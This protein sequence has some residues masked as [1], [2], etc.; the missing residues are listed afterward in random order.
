MDIFYVDLGRTGTGHTG[1]VADPYAWSDV[2]ASLSAIE[3]APLDSGHTFDVG[4]HFDSAQV[5]VVY[6]CRGAGDVLN[7][8]GSIDLTGLRFSP[9]SGIEITSWDPW[10]HGLPVFRTPTLSDLDAAHAWFK[11]TASTQVKLKIHGVVFGISLPN[12]G[13]DAKIISV[14]SPVLGSVQFYNN[15]VVD[16][17]AGNQ[18]VTVRGATPDFKTICTGN[19]IVY[20]SA[21]TGASSAF[22][23]ENG[24]LYTGLNFAVQASSASNTVIFGTSTTVAYSNGNA[25]GLKPSAIT[26]T[27]VSPTSFSPDYLGLTPAQGIWG[28]SQVTPANEDPVWSATAGIPVVKTSVF[29]PVHQGKLLG[30]GTTSVPA[31]IDVGTLSTD[32]LGLDRAPG[33]GDA[34]AFQKTGVTYSQTVHVDLAA[35]VS[36][37]GSETSP[38]TLADFVKDFGRRAPIDYSLSYVLRN[39][40]AAAL[41]G[42]DLGPLAP[43]TTASNRRFNG[44]GQVSITGYKTYAKTLP[45]LK[46]AAITP[47]SG[48][49]TTMSAMKLEFSGSDFIVP[50]APGS[51]P[52]RLVNSVVRS[53]PTA[54]GVI[55]RSSTGAGE[56]SLFG[57]SV[58][59]RHSV[60]TTTGVFLYPAGSTNSEISLCAV[61]LNNQNAVSV[62]NVK[63]RGCYVSTGT[64]GNPI[65]TGSSVDAYTKS[66]NNAFADPLNA[67]FDAA[68]FTLVPGSDAIGIVPGATQIQG[69]A[70]TATVTD[71]RGLTRSA[72]P[73]GDTSLDAGAYE[74]NFYVPDPDIVYLDMAK[75]RSG[76]GKP[77]DR[78][79]PAD[80]QTWCDNNS[81][82]V[83]RKKLQVQAVRSGQ[84]DLFVT[85]LE[86]DVNGGIDI[87]SEQLSNPILWESKD[88]GNITVRSCT[89]LSIDL[90][91]VMLRNTTGTPVIS[92]SGTQLCDLTA[93]ASVFD[94]KRSTTAWRLV[95]GQSWSGTGV[96]T[97]AQGS[98][99]TNISLDTPAGLYGVPGIVVALS[100]AGFSA[101]QR[102]DAIVLTV[103]GPSTVTPPVGIS[104]GALVSDI[105]SD[106]S[107]LVAGS[108]FNSEFS[109]ELGVVVNA[110]SGSQVRAYYCAAQGHA[111]SSTTKSG[112]FV[113]AT[114]KDV[115]WCG[116]NQ[117]T[118]GTQ[119]GCLHLNTQTFV[120]LRPVD[121]DAAA[122]SLF[123]TQLTGIATE[124][125]VAAV[126]SAVG[127]DTDLTGRLR[128][129]AFS[130]G[131]AT[132]D[133]GAIEM[134]ALEPTQSFDGTPSTC[135]TYVTELG[136][137]M[138]ARALAGD[139]Q[140]KLV[141]FAYSNSGYCYWAPERIVASIDAG[142][143]AHTVVTVSSNTGFSS[144]RLTV[145]TALGTVVVSYGSEFQSGATAADT[146][147]NIASALRA[148]PGFSKAC[149]CLA[150]GSTVTVYNQR[151]GVQTP[152]SVTITGTHLVASAPVLGIDSTGV[153]NQVF[154]T[155][156]YLP[157]SNV[158]V[159]EARARSFVARLGE[160]DGVFI[161]GEVAVIGQVVGSVFADEVDTTFVYAVSSSPISS[162]HDRKI[163]IKRFIFSY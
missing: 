59:L 73:N 58:Q 94:A 100:E 15:V 108:S 67:D 38:V 2:I 138:N 136:Y 156:G 93:T 6:K 106:G 125:D 128:S 129:Q 132:Y 63:I 109:E 41:S 28:P 26:Y 69:T 141:G 118:V 40:N 120:S 76:S 142:V 36:G 102:E 113:Q 37:T 14:E 55:V 60:G 135:S 152:P 84:L 19:T 43:D 71:C 121:T 9:T 25:F 75:T 78:W 88:F 140:F 24:T 162:K 27:G 13:A 39:Q 157:W 130:G 85:G 158:E 8:A 10:T 47:N 161:Y 22:R 44:G 139:V 21:A 119:N 46:I 143:Q 79:S 154:P 72:F 42:L 66:G 52:F 98:A 51:A 90:R 107:V 103:P 153:A 12:T 23:C 56:I 57:C 68:D 134:F 95:V 54:T 45:V 110:V 115:R 148:Q 89:G 97:V 122:F 87:V 151:Y 145:V 112:N 80:L 49:L 82:T 149:W 61:S 126:V 137:S 33:R 1:T 17:G 111:F 7:Q 150:S 65:F 116:G 16:N 81:G 91:R 160:S 146:A 29:W 32:A 64:G 133:A 159:P 114:T 147:K 5:N 31:A 117:V 74:A 48:V 11:L 92:F 3:Q 124:S 83:L 30:I 127:Y 163:A 105:E 62:G 86:A 123:D 96:L 18:L 101:V 99:Q 4:N 131:A 144:D 155:S 50:T 104:A 20:G 34:G 53:T 77:G 70:A 35:S